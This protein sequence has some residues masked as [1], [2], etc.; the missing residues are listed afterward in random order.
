MHRVKIM[1]LPNEAKAQRIVR[2]EFDR[3]VKLLAALKSTIKA[4][5]SDDGRP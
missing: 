2:R 1:Y 5:R 3:E 4:T